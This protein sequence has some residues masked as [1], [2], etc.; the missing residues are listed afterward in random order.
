MLK[1][2]FIQKGE[3][4]VIKTAYDPNAVEQDIYQRF[5]ES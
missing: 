5:G 3:G 4:V 2:V 1:V